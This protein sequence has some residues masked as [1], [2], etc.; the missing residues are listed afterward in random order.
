MDQ[1][2]KKSSASRK[3][4]SAS[5]NDRVTIKSNITARLPETGHIES[6]E[7]A[8]DELSRISK[9]FHDMQSSGKGGYQI[10]VSSHAVGAQEH[11]VSF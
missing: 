8:W 10:F 9:K 5:G 11:E 6:D 3:S 4:E 7:D 1:S 2:R